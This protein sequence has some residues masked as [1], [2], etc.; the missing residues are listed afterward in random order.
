[1][2][3]FLSLIMGIA[4]HIIRPVVDLIGI[5]LNWYTVYFVGNFPTEIFI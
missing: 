5:Q 2:I 3:L 1:M 4:N